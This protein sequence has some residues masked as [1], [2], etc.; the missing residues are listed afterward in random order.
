ML[1]KEAELD[2]TALSRATECR[3]RREHHHLQGGGGSCSTS[4]TS[5]VGLLQL[6]FG[7]HGDSLAAGLDQ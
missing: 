3:F 7:Q 5:A 4:T 6:L 2:H 1:R